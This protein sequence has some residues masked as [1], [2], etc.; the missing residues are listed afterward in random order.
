M[1]LQE[2]LFPDGLSPR[3]KA[4][5]SLIERIRAGETELF[6]ELVEPYRRSI[7]LTCASILDNKADAEEAFQETML[8]AIAY[9]HQLRLGQCL[10]GWLLQIAINEARLQCRKGKKHRSE[11]IDAET[12]EAEDSPVFWAALTDCHD[13]PSQAYER[14]ELRAAMARALRELQPIYREVFVLR[15]LQNISIS[16]AAMILGISETA[17]NSRLHRARIQMRQ[18]LAPFTRYKQSP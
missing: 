18:Q 13:T 2:V 1:S 5:I 14:R 6:A 15:E 3:Q 7:R 12:E 16:H 10:R 9:L 11:P 17:V 4:E 8:K